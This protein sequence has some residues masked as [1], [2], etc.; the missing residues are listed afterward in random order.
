[1]EKGKGALAGRGLASGPPAEAGPAHQHVTSLAAPA[2]TCGRPCRDAV[3]SRRSSSAAWRACAGA[4]APWS[5]TRCARPRPPPPPLPDTP[6]HSLSHPLLRL[7]ATATRATA[8][9][10]RWCSELL[11]PAAPA[12][13]LQSVTTS[14]SASP[15][16]TQRSRLILFGKPSAPVRAHPLAPGGGTP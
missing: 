4:D 13:S 11:S 16:R 8:R 3:A 6:L 12:S 5:A 9:H 14:D 7:C 15:F 1:M 10:C 2:S